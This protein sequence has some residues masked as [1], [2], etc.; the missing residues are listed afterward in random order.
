M[1]VHWP[2][3]PKS[4]SP[5]LGCGGDNLPCIAHCWA[6]AFCRR[7]M[8]PDHRAVAK[9]DGTVLLREKELVKPIARRK[10]TLYSV[11]LLGDLFHRN[12]ERDWHDSVLAI[13]ATTSTPFFNRGPHTYLVLTKRPDVAR[14]YLSDPNLAGWSRDDGSVFTWPL[15]NVWLGTSVS[16]DQDA[17]RIDDLLATPAAHHWISYEPATEPLR[18][19]QEHLVHQ[20]YGNS[21]LDAVIIGAESGPGRR[22]CPDKWLDD[23]AEQCRAANVP[24][25]VKQRNVAGR[26]VPQPLPAEWPWIRKE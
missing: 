20:S 24:A 13:M 6:K 8:H 23:V 2:G 16:G 12:V 14:E 1:G 19:F 15:Q 17:H 11:C 26:V 4:W 10:P 18:L 5:V 25:W 9:W 7:G 3:S 22:P 21:I